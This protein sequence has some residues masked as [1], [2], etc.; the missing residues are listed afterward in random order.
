V[1]NPTRSL[2]ELFAEVLIS[3][4]AKHDLHFREC[5]FIDVLQIRDVAPRVIVNK[6]FDSATF[7][8]KPLRKMAP[9]EARGAGHN[10]PLT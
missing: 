8:D 10:H 2:N 1:E 7:L 4:V 3:N 6:S 5:L 9:D